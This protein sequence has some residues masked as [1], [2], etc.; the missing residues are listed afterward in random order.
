MATYHRKSY[1]FGR[2]YKCRFG[3]MLFIE[4]ILIFTNI[5]VAFCLFCSVLLDVRIHF[6]V[7]SFLSW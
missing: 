6:E 7:L 1:R 3:N 4:V 2:K 5:H